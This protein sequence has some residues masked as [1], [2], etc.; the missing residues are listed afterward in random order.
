MKF[1]MTAVLFAVCFASVSDVFA[2]GR[3]HRHHHHHHRCV[4]GVCR[5]KTHK[6]VLWNFGKY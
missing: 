6:D 5:V 2:G 1:L 4:N 3:H